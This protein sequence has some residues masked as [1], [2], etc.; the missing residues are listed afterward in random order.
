MKIKPLKPEFTKP[1][2]NNLTVNIQN[3]NLK[4]NCT[5]QYVL[6]TDDDSYRYVGR[7]VVSGTDYSNWTGDNEFPYNHVIEKLNLEK[8]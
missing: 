7:V 1:T 5:L 8:V 3:D 2:V 4:D 6:S